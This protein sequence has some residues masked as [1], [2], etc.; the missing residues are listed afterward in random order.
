VVGIDI[1]R[2]AV[3]ELRERLGMTE[4]H[5]GDAQELDALG[6]G[7]FDLIVAGEVIEHLANPGRMLETAH[8]VLRE[9]GEI[10][11]TTAN[12]FCFRKLLRV[13]LGKESVHEDHVAYYSHR[14]LERLATMYGYFVAEQCSYRLPN[15]KPFIPYIMERVAGVL[16][17]NMCE[18]VI[19]RLQKE[20]NRV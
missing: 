7:R 13:L 8:A 15:K 16:S 4:I 12:A 14:T 10:I 3:K 17:P 9:D 6:L 5:W 11:I 20:R 18:G 19:C 2:E 1:E